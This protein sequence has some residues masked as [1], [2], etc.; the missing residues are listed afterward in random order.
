MDDGPSEGS[1]SGGAA[2]ASVVAPP[3]VADEASVM[4]TDETA[5]TTM[6]PARAWRLLVEAGV[7]V[8]SDTPVVERV[9]RLSGESVRPHLGVHPQPAHR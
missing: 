2:G 6:T 1:R 5:M 3:V 4:T 8:E 9:E 7:L